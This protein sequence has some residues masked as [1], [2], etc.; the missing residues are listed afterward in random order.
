MKGRG[1][2]AVAMLPI[3]LSEWGRGVL[4]LV[5]FG[6][7]WFLVQGAD[8][9]TDRGSVPVPAA[10]GIRFSCPGLFRFTLF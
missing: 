6:F 3:Q 1:C 7:V 5:R 8:S 2:Y 9:G 10:W 4:R